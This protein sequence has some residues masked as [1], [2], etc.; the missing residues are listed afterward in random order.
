MCFV[1]LT[2]CFAQ[3]WAMGSWK[4]NEANSKFI[5]GVSK[6]VTIV[7]EAAGDNIKCTKDGVDGQGKP[8]HTEWTGKFDGEDYPLIGD[9][10]GDMRA[11][12]RVSEREMQEITKKDGN[13]I[14]R[15][16]VVV[17]NDGKTV[18]VITNG[19]DSEGEKVYNVAIYDKQ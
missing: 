1:C 3:D 15:N 4:L 6:A 13:V 9:S 10:K 17:F 14:G 8:L 18:S 5:P 16:R 2:I 19:A 7:F 12:K 11:Y